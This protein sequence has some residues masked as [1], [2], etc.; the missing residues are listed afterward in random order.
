MSHQSSTIGIYDKK[1]DNNV[2]QLVQ[3][4]NEYAVKIP[5]QP[6]FLDDS[7][8]NNE[9]LEVLIQHKLKER[10]NELAEIQK[11]YNP[12]DMIESVKLIKISS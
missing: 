6:V 1:E 12:D 11:L 4:T 2:A 3:Y 8:M 7:E 10:D 5:P 9:E